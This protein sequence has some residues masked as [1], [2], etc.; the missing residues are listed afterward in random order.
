MTD[1]DGN[2]LIELDES[3]PMRTHT[4]DALGY[5]VGFAFPMRPPVRER[6]CVI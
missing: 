4:S 6:P 3:D 5:Y 1:A 2:P